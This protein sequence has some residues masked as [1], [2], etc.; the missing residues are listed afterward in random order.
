[1]TELETLGVAY[2]GLL[3]EQLFIESQLDYDI[4]E[5]HKLFL[6]QLS[7]KSVHYE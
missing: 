6:E 3:N 1:M 2:F 5:K 4:F 7:L